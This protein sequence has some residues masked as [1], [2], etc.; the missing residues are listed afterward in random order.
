MLCPLDVFEDPPVEFKD[1]DT[2]GS[3]WLMQWR[4]SGSLALVEKRV[5]FLPSEDA[6]FQYLPVFYQILRGCKINITHWLFHERA[7]QEKQF[8]GSHSWK[9]KEITQ[10]WF[11]NYLA[12]LPAAILSNA[13]W[14]RNFNLGSRRWLAVGIGAEDPVIGWSSADWLVEAAATNSKDGAEA[15]YVGG[16]LTFKLKMLKVSWV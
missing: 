6:H 1:A 11:G 13:F 14:T 5:I 16:K 9:H 12:N 2:A 8:H 10:R 3:T 4:R 7:S 15:G